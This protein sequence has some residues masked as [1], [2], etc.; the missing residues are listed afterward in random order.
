M[1]AKPSVH[2]QTPG[3]Y[4]KGKARHVVVRYVFEI[5]HCHVFCHYDPKKGRKAK[6]TAT[7]NI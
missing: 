5:P 3:S 6:G 2:P 7:Y 4:M 1:G